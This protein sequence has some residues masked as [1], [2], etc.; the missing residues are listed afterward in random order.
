MLNTRYRYKDRKTSMFQQN[1]RF[2]DVLAFPEIS[3]KY[4]QSSTARTV[5]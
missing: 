3:E 1:D 5:I 2:F 4:T